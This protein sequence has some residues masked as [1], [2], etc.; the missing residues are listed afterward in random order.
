MKTVITNDIPIDFWDRSPERFCLDAGIPI[1][2]LD[3]IE[4]EELWKNC[5]IK[6]QKNPEV[7]WLRLHQGEVSHA[8]DY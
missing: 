6:N 1:G 5:C 4:T 2:V 7:E 3:S 8:Q